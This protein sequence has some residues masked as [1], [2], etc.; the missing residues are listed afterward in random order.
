MGRVVEELHEELHG[1]GGR[2]GAGGPGNEGG[3]LNGKGRR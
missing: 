1:E 2:G 3:A